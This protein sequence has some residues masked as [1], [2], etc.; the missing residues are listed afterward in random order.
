MTLGPKKKKIEGYINNEEVL[1]AL[2]H[3]TNGKSPGSDRFTAELFIF[4]KRPFML[5]N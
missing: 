5:F 1:L 3:T 4:L 2:N